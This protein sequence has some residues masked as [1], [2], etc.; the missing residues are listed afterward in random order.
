MALPHRPSP[1]QPPLITPMAVVMRVMTMTMTIEVMMM[2]M[3]MMM[4][5]IS[6]TTY[7]LNSYGKSAQYFFWKGGY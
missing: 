6:P 5:I 4:Y 1:L 7:L 2:M 3:M